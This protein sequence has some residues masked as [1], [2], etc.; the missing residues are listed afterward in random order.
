MYPIL[1][2]PGPSHPNNPFF[3]RNL[4]NKH[5]LIYWVPTQPSP[6]RKTPQIV[7][8]DERIKTRNPRAKKKTSRPYPITPVPSFKHHSTSCILYLYIY[9]PGIVYI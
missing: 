5:V 8:L 7:S 1:E 3:D 9:K 6:S 4:D 2:F